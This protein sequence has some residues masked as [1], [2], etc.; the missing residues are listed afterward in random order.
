MKRIKQF[1]DYAASQEEAIITFNASD[2][3]LNI[4]SDVS[5]LSKHNAHS[6]AG[7]HHFLS[8]ATDHAPNNS[9][10]LNISSI[11]RNVMPSVVEAEL[12]ALFLNSKTAVPARKTLE[13]LGHPQPRTPVQTDN[14][15]AEG[16]IN[17]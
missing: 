11:I 16:L 1:L 8:N 6:R 13:E 2:I 14:K 4:H 5:Y 3:I 15:T 7:G 17:C 9:A 12:G 10:V